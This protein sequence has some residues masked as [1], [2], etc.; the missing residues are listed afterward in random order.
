MGP[1]SFLPDEGAERYQLFTSATKMLSSDEDPHKTLPNIS[2][3]PS[4][5]PTVNANKSI[6]EPSCIGLSGVWMTV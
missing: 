3:T 5:T 2:R 4:N 6:G 1:C